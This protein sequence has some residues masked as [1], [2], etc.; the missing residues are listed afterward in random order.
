M[1]GRLAATSGEKHGHQ[2]EEMM[3][4]VGET[5]MAID[6]CVFDTVDM[7]G[8]HAFSA[9]ERG[10]RGLISRRSLRESRAIFRC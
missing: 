1:V 7:L 8:L 3:A 4:V 5:P 9:P 10:Y 2:W 6:S